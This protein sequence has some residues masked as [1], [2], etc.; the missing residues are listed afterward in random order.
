[1]LLFASCSNEQKHTSGFRVAIHITGLN[2]P[3]KVILEKMINK[4]W[5]RLDSL[6]LQDGKG[7]ITGK[8]EFP[9]LYYLTIKKFNIHIPFWLE[10]SKISLTAGL[11][12]WRHPVVKGS[13]AQKE[14]E[15][16]LDSVKI[17]RLQ[18]KPVT[19]RISKAEADN[20]PQKAEAIRKEYYKIDN[21]RIQYTFAFAVRHNNSAISPYLVLKNCYLTPLPKL[22]SLTSCFNNTLPQN[23]YVKLLKKHVAVL[24]SVAPGKHFTDFTLNDTLG[25]PISLSSVVSSHKYTLVDF[26]ASWCPDCRAEN[27][28]IVAAFK[29]FHNKGFTVFGVSLDRIHRNWMQGIHQQELYWTQVSDLKGW[30]SAPGQLYGVKWIPHNLL[31]NQK[32]IIVAQDLAGTFLQNKLKALLKK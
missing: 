15:A 30:H 26:W 32:G 20:N 31:I 11:R 17:F 3:T 6:T 24:K 7:T 28:E 27:P 9:E 21:Q 13:G 23:P 5:E 10:N 22:D 14:Y 29:R 18:E 19:A 1:M 16:Y 4:S 2:A 8:I 25:K 12:S